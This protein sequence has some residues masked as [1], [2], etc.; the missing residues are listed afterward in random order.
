MESGVR[1]AEEEAGEMELGR[2][3]GRQVILLVWLVSFTS[4]VV[5]LPAP[6]AG[7]VQQDAWLAMLLGAAVVL[8]G[9]WAIVALGLRFANQDLV[10]CAGALAGGGGRVLV[11]FLYAA[12]FLLAGALAMRSGAELFATAFMPE[13]PLLVFLLLMGAVAVVG[14]WYGLEV[15]ARSLEIVFPLV[16]AVSAFQVLTVLPGVELAQVQPVGFTLLHRPLAAAR[17]ILIVAAGLG[18]AAVVGF[19]LPALYDP[20]AGLREGMLGVALAGLFLGVIIFAMVAIFGAWE[21]ATFTFPAVELARAVRI[22]QFVERVESVIISIWL[23]IGFLKLA[24][25]LHT[26]AVALAGALQRSSYRPFVLPGGVAMTA[27]AFFLVKNVTELIRLLTGW[28]VYAALGLELA[29]PLLLWG[30]ASLQRR[31]G[32]RAGGRKA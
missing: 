2:I 8:P 1:K 18:E 25:L 16:L 20:R 32:R 15:I 27:L 7:L 5:L 6:V 19:F 14:A 11:G 31:E 30:W 28:W 26:A 13:T 24:L 12:F 23:I 9:V 29:L 4:L 17:A 3:G 21:P 10:G 22:A